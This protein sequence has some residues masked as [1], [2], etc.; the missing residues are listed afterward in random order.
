MSDA[1]TTSAAQSM[2]E[3]ES[4]LKEVR[5]IFKKRLVVEVENKADVVRAKTARLKVS[6]LTGEGIEPLM[7]HLISLLPDKSGRPAWAVEQESE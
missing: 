1:E 6:A 2:K 3:Q 5:A 4:L 7:R